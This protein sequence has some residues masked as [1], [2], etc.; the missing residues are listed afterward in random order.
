MKAEAAKCA[1][2]IP[3]TGLRAWEF[4]RSS[5]QTNAAEKEKMHRSVHLVKTKTE[6]RH[7]QRRRTVFFLHCAKNAL[8][9]R[10]DFA[11]T[12]FR[13][14]LLWVYARLCRPR[15]FRSEVSSSSCLLFSLPA[16]SRR[17]SNT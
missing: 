10:S 17:A 6:G 11:T 13:T 7:M 8:P 12:L 2:C 9:N 15:K 14:T 3:A 1:L 16:T 4:S 5:A